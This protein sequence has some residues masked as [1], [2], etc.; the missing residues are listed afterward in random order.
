MADFC[1]ICTRQ[2]FLVD[3]EPDYDVYEYISTC[4]PNQY[5]TTICEGCAMIAVGKE[6]DGTVYIITLTPENIE[7]KWT[8]AEWESGEL[9]KVY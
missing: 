7:K 9:A 1:E 4:Q 3:T 6:A 5:V 2:M 8:L